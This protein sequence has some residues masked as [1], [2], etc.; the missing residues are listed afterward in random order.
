MLHRFL[1]WTSSPFFARLFLLIPLL[2]WIPLT[3]WAT[4]NEG[5]DS[6]L[7]RFTLGAFG[8]TLGMMLMAVTK[9]A[10][11]WMEILLAF[12]G[13]VLMGI[14]AAGILPCFA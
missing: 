12:L 14:G 4:K 9:D 8:L 3:L 10:N 2:I 13:L 7:V 1:D 6:E 11:S 5:F